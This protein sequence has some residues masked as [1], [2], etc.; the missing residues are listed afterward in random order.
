MQTPA[1]VTVIPQQVLSDQ[2]VTTVQQAMRDAPGVTVGAGS[3][4][5][6]GQPYSAIFMRGFPATSFLR[7]GVRSLD[8]DNGVF[9]TDFADVDQV[10]VLKGP[11]AILYGALEP[12]GVVNYVTKQPQSAPAYSIEQ[13][14]GSYGA[15]E[16]ASTLRAPSE[17]PAR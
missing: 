8:E 13:Q 1:S 7:N 14:V 5:D 9:S 10:Q 11:A 12:G 16:P 4:N 3:A 15:I 17:R 2:A 6:S